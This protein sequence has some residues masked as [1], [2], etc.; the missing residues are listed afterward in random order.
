VDEALA[1]LGLARTVVVVV[2]SFAAALAIARASDLV[3]L[4]PSSFRA[5]VREQRS[6][7]VGGGLRSF[8]LPVETKAIAISQMWHPRMDGDSAHRWLRG[9]ILAACRDLGQS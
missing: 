9:L 4:I 7:P 3:A 2:P 6:D 1:A 5:A 8:P